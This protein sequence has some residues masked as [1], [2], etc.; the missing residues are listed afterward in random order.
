MRIK[1][2]SIS[3]AMGGLTLEG[4]K[5]NL[6]PETKGKKVWMGPSKFTY[7]I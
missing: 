1:K 3:Q 4:K 7:D 5:D 6:S 2:F